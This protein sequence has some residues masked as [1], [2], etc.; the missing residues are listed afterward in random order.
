MN[1]REVFRFAVRQMGEA[2]LRVLERA[3][4]EKEDLDLLILT[5][6]IFVSW[7]LLASV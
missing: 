2:S 7:K 6:Q 4:L 3:G 1:G 5:K